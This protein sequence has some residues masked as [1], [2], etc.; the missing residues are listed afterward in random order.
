MPTWGFGDASSLTVIIVADPAEN[1][2]DRGVSGISAYT[3]QVQVQ[4]AGCRVRH[5]SGAYRPSTCGF[6]AVS[7]HSST[8]SAMWQNI[9]RSRCQICCR[10]PARRPVRASDRMINGCSPPTSSLASRTPRRRPP[11]ASLF[12][13]VIGTVVAAISTA[14]GPWSSTMTAGLFRREVF[15]WTSATLRS[16]KRA[17]VAASR[18]YSRFQH[19]THRCRQN[20][21]PTCANTSP[22]P[23]GSRSDP[24][25][26]PR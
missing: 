22:S 18:G 11:I 26:L 23:V 3:V 16:P 19:R 7:A 21:I 4:P 2:S 24:G 14:L 5:Q 12:T 10:H 13:Q 15:S 25:V 6:T 1:P 20:Y 8:T 9:I 17:A